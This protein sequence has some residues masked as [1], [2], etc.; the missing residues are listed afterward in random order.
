MS[1]ALMKLGRLMI[2]TTVYITRCWGYLTKSCYIFKDVL[3]I[4]IDADVLKP[5]SE[6]KKMTT[7]MTTIAPLHFGRHL[8]LAPIGVVPIPKE[9]LRV[10]NTNP[11]NKK[12]KGLVSVSTPQ[13]EIMWVH[14]NLIETQQW[15]TITNRKA[16]KRLEHLLVM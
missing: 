4:L 13:R 7:N 2:P 8:P 3:Q 14:P 12:E 9:E 16:K 6:Q 10:I 15:M 1:D 5:R 11:C